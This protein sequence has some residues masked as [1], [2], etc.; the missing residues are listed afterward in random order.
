MLS[1]LKL[2]GELADFCGGQNQ[3]EAVINHPIDAIRFLK[4]NFAGLEQHMS[5]NFY[6]VYIGNFNIDEELLDFPSG[7]LDIKIVPV[8][9]GA[10]NIG[11]IIAGVALLGFAIATGG[12]GGKI[13]TQGIFGAG[14]GGWMLGSLNV[15][16]L[17]GK[18]GVLLVLSG[19]AGLLTPT[20]ELPDDEADPIKSFSFSGVQNTVRSGT[21]IPVIYGKMLVGSI[22][23][24]TKIQ[25]NDIE[26]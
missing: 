13:L 18:I 7:G 5:K 17:A 23:V 16:A 1:K 21:A 19:V 10:G 20:P 22:P 24:S 8:V 14:K 15:S 2:Y 3:F 26:A 12:I 9:S 4:A 11:K 6:R 25:T